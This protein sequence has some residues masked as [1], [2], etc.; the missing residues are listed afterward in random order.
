M[1][2]KLTRTHACT[3]AHTQPHARALTHKRMHTSETHTHTRACT[4]TDR[5]T[6]TPTPHARMRVRAHGAARTR[7]PDAVLCPV[8]GVHGACAVRICERALLRR[9]NV[10]CASASSAPRAPCH[11]RPTASGTHTPF[12]S[13]SERLKDAA[14]PSGPGNV[15]AHTPGARHAEATPVF[16]SSSHRYLQTAVHRR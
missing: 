14:R 16:V 15:V 8:G 9:D 3:H 7:E 4:N 10:T 5:H 11:S 6:R 13:H 1:P 2:A 12:A